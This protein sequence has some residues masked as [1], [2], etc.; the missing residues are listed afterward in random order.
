MRKDRERIKNGH[1]GMEAGGEEK[2]RIKEKKGRGEE[3]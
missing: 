2:E 3:M 1:V